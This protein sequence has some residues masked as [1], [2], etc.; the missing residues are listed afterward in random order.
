MGRHE[1]T[2]RQWNRI[3]PM[4]PGR[5]GNPGRSA[6]DNRLFINAVLWIAKTGVPC[7]ICPNAL[8]N[9]TRSFNGLTA[10]VNAA[11]GSGCS[12]PWAAMVNW[13]ICCSIPRLSGRTSMRPAQK[14]GKQRSV[15]AIPWRLG[16]EDP[17]GRE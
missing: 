9:G 4:L 10:G 5:H 6:A 7:G 1:L 11:S 8:V 14:G 3:E 16:H 13:S 17:R 2:D 15:W 12:K